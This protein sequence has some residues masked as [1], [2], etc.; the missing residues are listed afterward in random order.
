MARLFSRTG[1]VAHDNPGY[2]H[3]E[4]DARGGFDFPD[5]LS[6]ELI[7]FH[8]RKVPMWEDETGRQGRLAAE[9]EARMRDP[10]TLAALVSQLVRGQFPQ[11]VPPEPAPAKTAPKAPARA[12]ASAGR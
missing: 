1:A 12:G 6:D 2:G 11:S 4:A 10:A 8:V 9:E 7:R 3:F 5:D